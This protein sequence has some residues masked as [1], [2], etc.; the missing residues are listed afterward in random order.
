MRMASLGRS[1]LAAL[2]SALIMVPWAAPAAPGRASAR[3]PNGG[4]CEAFRNNEPQSDSFRRFL[5][6]LVRDIRTRIN[7]IPDVGL[8]EAEGFVHRIGVNHIRR[9]IIYDRAWLASQPINRG[10]N[11]VAT[12]LI[13][14]EIGHFFLRQ[15]ERRHSGETLTNELAADEFAG[16][17]MRRL[18]LDTGIGARAFRQ[19]VNHLEVRGATPGRNARIAA[20]ERGFNAAAPP[21][22]TPQRPPAAEDEREA[23]EESHNKAQPAAPGGDKQ[24]PPVAPAPSLWRQILDFI[25]EAG[26]TI[27]VIGASAGVLYGAYRWLRRRSRR[28]SARAAL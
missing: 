6:S 10:R 16:F 22:A 7:A 28:R 24:A 17:A 5:Q 26:T 20:F 4:D 11:E 19:V 2:L 27:T 21:A 25:N 18:G 15:R 9:L 13:A 23:A 14:H 12:V 1:A 8:C 3:D